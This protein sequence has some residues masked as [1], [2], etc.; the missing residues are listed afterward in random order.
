MSPAMQVRRSETAAKVESEKSTGGVTLFGYNFPLSCNEKE[1]RELFGKCG[2][3]T[4]VQPSI[5]L[6]R[7]AGRMR[8]CRIRCACVS[9]GPGGQEGPTRRLRVRGVQGEGRSPSVSGC[10]VSCRLPLSHGG[11]RLGA[12]LDAAVAMDGTTLNKK[13]INCRRCLD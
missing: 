7:N 13:K 3:I 10:C 6:C 4:Q 9:T 11:S 1:L 5:H 8:L 2:E 12:G